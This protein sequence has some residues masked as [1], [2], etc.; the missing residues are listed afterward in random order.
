M[1]VQRAPRQVKGLLTG[2]CHLKG[3]LFKL[4]LTDSPTCGRF[5][6]KTQTASHILCECLTLAKL[7]FHCLSTH[8]TELSHYDEIPLCKILYFNSGMGLLAEIK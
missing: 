5:H 1:D 8:I 3:H 2:H 7:R 6:M 4:D